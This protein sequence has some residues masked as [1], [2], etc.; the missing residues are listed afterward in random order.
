MH[1]KILFLLH[2]PPPVH[3]SSMVG[4]YIYDSFLIN[5]TFNTSYI[6][7]GTSKSIDEIGKNPLGKIRSYISIVFKTINQLITNKPSVVYIAINSRGIGFY[8]DVVIA[9]LAKLFGMQLLLHFHNKGV[10]LNQ[11]NFIDN[12]LYKW[13]FKNTKVILLSKYLYADIKKYVNES[14]VYYCPNGIPKLNHAIYKKPNHKETVQL[15]FLSN[16]IESKGVFVLLEAMHELKK[17]GFNFHCN[18]V[19]GEGDIS[20][21]AFNESVHELK[22][23]THVSYLGKKYEAEKIA[24]YKNSDVF[25]L[26]TFYDKEC[27]P[28]VLLEA[29]QFALPLVSTFEGAIPEIVENGVNGYLVPKNDSDALVEK[30]ELLIKDPA[31]RAALGSNALIKFNEL[32]SLEMFEKNMGFILNDIKTKI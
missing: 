9:F 23:E 22:L 7:L 4:K 25:V 30:L 8:K 5:N 14:D 2:L 24:I 28:L 20:A 1:K 19:G 18:F 6:N 11:E 13:V 3:G 32:Y 26:P 31:L 21:K 15:L 17:K 12:W 16:L 27:F 10:A 29:S